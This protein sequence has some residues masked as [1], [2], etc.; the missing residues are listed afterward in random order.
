[1]IGSGRQPKSDGTNLAKPRGA[2]ADVATPAQRLSKSDGTNLA[3]PPGETLPGLKS[4]GTNLANPP[5]GAKGQCPSLRNRENE[6]SCPPVAPNPMKRDRPCVHGCPWRAVFSE[7]PK[8][9]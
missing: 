2:V 1:M 6:L 8:I 3:N 9:R 5:S 7:E 4:D